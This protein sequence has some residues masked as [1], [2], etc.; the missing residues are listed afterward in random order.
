[1]HVWMVMYETLN[2]C[3][4]NKLRCVFIIENN[5]SQTTPLEKI[6]QVV[7]KTDLM[8]LILMQRYYQPRFKNFSRKYVL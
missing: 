4:L 2:F 8:F 7:S 5:Y 6:L 1:M 3:S